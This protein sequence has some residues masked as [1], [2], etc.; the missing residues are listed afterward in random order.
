MYKYIFPHIVG[1]GGKRETAQL[2]V[3]WKHAFLFRDSAP[4]V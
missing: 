2:V 1:R 4:Q 3:H